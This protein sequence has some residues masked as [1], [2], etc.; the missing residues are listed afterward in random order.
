M[1]VFIKVE[2]LQESELHQK[3]KL[4][5]DEPYYSGAKKII[6]SWTSNFHDKDNKIVTEFQTTFHS[7]LWEFYL[8]AM[9]E[10][11]KLPLEVKY[12]RPDFI[13]SG[14]S[15][16]YVE[17][18]VSEIKNGGVPESERSFDDYL[19]MLT[20]I[21]TDE[22]FSTLINEAIVRHSH[23]INK[24]LDKYTGFYDKN[25]KRRKPGYVEDSGV[26]KNKPYVIALASYDQINYGKEYIYSMMA[27][28]YGLYF[29]PEKN[30]YLEKS[31]IKKP[32]SDSD[33]KLGIF[34]D[35]R[36]RNV[37]AVIFSN[38]LTLGKLSSLSKSIGHD[39]AHVINIR[40]DYE[41]PHYKIHEVDTSNP[42]F[43]L[44]G[45]YVFHNPNAN[46]SFESDAISNSGMLQITKDSHGLAM[47]GERRP[48]VARF[49]SFFGHQY[50]ELIKST[51]ASS[52]NNTIAFDIN[53]N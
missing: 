22:E 25:K 33:I 31:S 52:Y 11:L 44:D 19:S 18:V 39:P 38:T 48:I 7:S 34:N 45:V 4:I 49:C 9:F 26:D 20:P 51:A 6:E 35:E 17:A 46:V 41:A 24:K 3:F 21:S 47:M 16:F 8:H 5:R 40:Y 10:E 32:G 37:S 14:D 53:K 29:S 42:E 30:T 27:L 50:S 43:L 1:D 2:S 12:N 15:Q 23:S 28:L 36:M 13:I